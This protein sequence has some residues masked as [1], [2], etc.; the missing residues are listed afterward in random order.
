MLI[1][2]DFL[3]YMDSSMAN[4]DE[5]VAREGFRRAREIDELIASSIQRFFIGRLIVRACK[6]KHLKIAS[7][8]SRVVSLELREWVDA[9][10]LDAKFEVV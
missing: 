7:A 2:K 10:N 8:L 4:L 9:K 5:L 3:N 1:A 6:G